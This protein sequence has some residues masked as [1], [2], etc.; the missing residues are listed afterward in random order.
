MPTPTDDPDYRVLSCYLTAHCAPQFFFSA[1]DRLIKRAG[2]RSDIYVSPPDRPKSVMHKK[3]EISAELVRAWVIGGK[4]QE[5]IAEL[6]GCK[7]R[8]VCIFMKQHNIKPSYTGKGRSR[9]I[10]VRIDPAF[11]IPVQVIPS[12]FSVHTQAFNR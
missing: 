7:V 1:L 6:C 3:P 4:T 12:G 9:N 2:I 10:E 11:P 8:T 5:Q